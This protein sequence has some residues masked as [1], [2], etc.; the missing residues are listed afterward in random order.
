[1]TSAQPLPNASL[2]PDDSLSLDVTRTDDTEVVYRRRYQGLCTRAR[3]ELGLG[4]EAQLSPAALVDHL[5]KLRPSI[6]R[7]TWRQYKA[8]SLFGLREEA[9]RPAARQECLEAIARLTEQG[10]FGAP[11]RIS[12]SFK[13]KRLPDKDLKAIAEACEVSRTETSETLLLWLY[14]TRLTGLR[15]IE[16]AK[17][18]FSDRYHDLGPALIIRNAKATNGRAHGPTR[19]LLL[20]QLEQREI[21]LIQ[22]CLAK[23]KIAEKAGRFSRL[24][25]TCSK[26]LARINERLWPGRQGHYTIYS[27]RH[28]FSAN[29][30][31]KFSRRAVAGL[32]GHATDETAAR[33][34]G[35][36]ENAQESAEELRLP[37]PLGANVEAVK[38][39]FHDHHKP[40]TARAKKVHQEGS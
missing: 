22:A 9:G 37:F 25:I 28:Q 5:I 34:Y 3:R 24:Y 31:T 36:R 12:S 1:M 20:S 39:R 40:E 4:P 16:W 35:R 17:T 6:G 29:V 30:K 10:S 13:I 33:H 32:M 26:L 18:E 21:M 38:E 19:V 15:P 8:A 2:K 11:R 7:S 23:I 14:A 27:A